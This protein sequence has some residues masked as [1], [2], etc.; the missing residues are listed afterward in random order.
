MTKKSNKRLGYK[1]YAWQITTRW[2]VKFLLLSASFAVYSFEKTVGEAVTL[3]WTPPTEYEN[4]TPIQNGELDFY[5]I[6]WVCDANGSGQ[7]KVTAPAIT[8]P[9]T[10]YMLGKCSVT[11]TVTDIRGME[12]R[13]SAEIT[14]IVKLPKPTRGGFR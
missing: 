11:I 10:G 9:I 12:S 4:N 8:A 14:G 6:F 2:L 1:I 7:I 5:T 13:H 3:S